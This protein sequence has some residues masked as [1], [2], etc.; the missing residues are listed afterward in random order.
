MLSILGAHVSSG[1]QG[2]GFWE[3]VFFRS[4]HQ[5]ILPVRH[6]FAAIRPYIYKY[7][8]NF[9]YFRKMCNYA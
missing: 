8:R 7:I 3:V 9:R 6:N 1:C 5:E 2:F 4:V